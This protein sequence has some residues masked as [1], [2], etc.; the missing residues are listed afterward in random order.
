MVQIVILCKMEF[1]IKWEKNSMKRF[2]LISMVLYFC[3]L[4]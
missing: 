4:Q 3:K 2:A 1:S